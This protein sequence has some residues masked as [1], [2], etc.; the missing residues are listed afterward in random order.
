MPEDNFTAPGQLGPAGRA[1]DPP[2]SG[3]GIFVFRYVEFVGWYVYNKCTLDTYQLFLVQCVCVGVPCGQQDKS[4]NLYW[5][6]LPC[7]HPILTL[8]HHD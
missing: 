2:F 4:R 6:A 1:A 8:G 7:S 5:L 3:I